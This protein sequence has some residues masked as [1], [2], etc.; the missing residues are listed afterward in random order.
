MGGN[1]NAARQGK[2]THPLYSRLNLGLAAS[3]IASLGLLWFHRHLLTWPGIMCALLPPLVDP[4]LC[5]SLRGVAA[6]PLKPQLFGED[7]QGPTF[8]CHALLSSVCA[9]RT[10]AALLAASLAVALPPLMQ[11]GPGA[12]LSAIPE[13]TRNTRNRR[14]ALYALMAV[15]FFVEGLGIVPTPGLTLKA[16]H[17]TA[18]SPVAHL[19]IR[20]VALGTHVLVPAICLGLKARAHT[21]A[22]MAGPPSQATISLTRLA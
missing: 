17:G 21:P 19:L 1:Q 20:A 5:C 6:C 11:T 2:L 9:S 13:D 10:A 7:L 18:G 3:A 4:R 14:S 15:L 8:P 16:L 12:V 22:P